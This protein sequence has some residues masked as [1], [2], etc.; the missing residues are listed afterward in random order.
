MINGNASYQRE[1]FSQNG[2][3]S[4]AKRFHRLGADKN[5][6]HQHLANRVRRLLGNRHLGPRQAANRSRRRASRS[7]RIPAP[8]HARLDI[9]RTCAGLYRAARRPDP[10]HHC[11]SESGQFE[12][13]FA[14]DE[15]LRR[16]RLDNRPRCRKRRGASGGDP[17]NLAHPR[18]PGDGTDQC[19]EPD[20]RRAARS[21]ARR[22][23]ASKTN[24]AGAAARA[25]RHSFRA[26]PPPPRHSSG[27]SAAPCGDGHNRCRRGRF[28]SA[29]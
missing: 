12:R 13:N 1:L 3:V 4:L 22:T 29:A 20:S 15:N 10:N 8:R 28:L 24:T 6:A 5:A 11:E 21:A 23:R 25:A 16:K 9:G 2:I 19:L 26:R 14:I 7:R 17:R 27:G 18:R